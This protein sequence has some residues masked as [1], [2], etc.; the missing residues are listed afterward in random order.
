MNKKVVI[1][2]FLI[3]SLASI[4]RLWDLG[5]TP[6]S[7]NWDEVSLGYNAYSIL[8]TGRDEYG[9]VLPLVLRS[10]DDYKPALYAHIVIPF[11]KIFGLDVVSV[12]LPSAIFGI[13]SVVATFFLIKE[14]FKRV[15]ISL[16]SSLLL[17]VSPWHIQF[18]RIAFESNIGLSFNIF[19][20][21]FFLK[22]LKKPL[23]LPL[24]FALMSVNFYM[25]QSEKVF[26]PLF[27]VL[28]IVV[29]RKQL[30]KISPKYIASAIVI[31]FLISL[32]M[33][34]FTLTDKNV[35]SRAKGVSVFSD[36]T[37]LLKDN[38]QKLIVD[39]NNNDLLG[40][41]LDNRRIVFAKSVI[42]GYISHFD[43]NWLFITGD[44]SRHHAPNMGLLYLYELPFLFVG[45][46][47]LIFLG[48]D[49]RAKL[50]ILG[51][52]LIAPIP[53]SITSG[54]PHAVRTLNFL[55]TFQIFT[56]IGLLTLLALISN[57]KYKIAK[58]H[59]IYLISTLYILFFIFNFSY[60]LNQYFVQQNYFASYDW[61]YGYED[62][63]SKTSQISGKYERIVV[64]NVPHMDQSYMFFLFYL[65]YP[66]QLYQKETQG[67]SGGFRED[68]KFGKFE[69]RPIEWD[70]EE[71]GNTLYIGRSE[72]FPQSANSV[73]TIDFLD[74]KPAIK[75]VEG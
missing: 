54:V 22:G 65:R 41:I 68:H 24:S 31:G 1:F 53:A 61:Q 50:F 12:R 33:I 14:L 51:W 29:F 64:S 11:V 73:K 59:I 52:F 46:Y 45:I 3:V 47:S 20:A 60:Y 8:E 55:P 56:A 25:Y 32:P 27:A 28:L 36:I 40:L 15:D 21:L 9:K 37:P 74:G 72:D 71:R 75:I 35:L 10:F 67:A 70:K 5:K 48:F 57:I 44:L 2:F 38:A 4:L 34:I 7:P 13:L 19:S 49:R 23:F 42:S 66:P 18:S 63:V 30:F 17:A 69:F 16:M 26:V 39:R 43:L 58:I 6:P 62:A